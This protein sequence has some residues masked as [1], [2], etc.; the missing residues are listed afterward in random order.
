MNS[1]NDVA[2]ELMHVLRD[3]RKTTIALAT[4]KGAAEWYGEYAQS[5][6]LLF[7]DGYITWLAAG[8]K[9]LT[10]DGLCAVG[11]SAPRAN[12]AFRLTLQGI[13][14]MPEAKYYL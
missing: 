12:E 4:I 11:N 7:A 3:E 14:P 1:P 5:Q 9:P 10:I 13:L 8:M 6:Y 2:A